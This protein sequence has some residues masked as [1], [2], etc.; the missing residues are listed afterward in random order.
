MTQSFIAEVEVRHP[1]LP[2]TPTIQ[3]IP[4]IEI[5]VEP[6][7][8][9][10]ES[11]RI[12]CSVVGADFQRFESALSN[13]PTVDDSWNPME[14]TNCRIYQVHPSPKAKFTTP[15]IADLGI[16]LLSIQSADEAWNFRLQ[17]PNKEALGT[18]WQYC[19]EE[20][21]EFHLKKLYSSGPQATAGDTESLK[22]HLTSRQLE[23]ARTAA[24]M[25]YYDQDGASAEEVAEELGIS[26]STLSTHI[27]NIMSNFFNHMFDENV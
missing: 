5:Q 12:F 10:R 7:P 20:N 18:Y 26:P 15:K 8:T 3:Q 19:R 1:D 27:R 14:L 21:V 11:P 2:L 25:S 13:D 17:A 4:D 16:R 6:Q 24:R 9:Y 23:V 22:A